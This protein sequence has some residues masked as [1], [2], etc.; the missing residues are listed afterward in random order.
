MR[1]PGSGK[2]SWN[3]DPIFLT[4]IIF[5]LTGLP[6]DIPDGKAAVRSFNISF[7]SRENEGQ[8]IIFV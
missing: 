2:N 8:S 3:P 1:N 5:P 6:A 4:E 7:Y